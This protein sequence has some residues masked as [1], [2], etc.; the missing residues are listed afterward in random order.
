[1][2]TTIQVAKET[3]EKLDEMGAS[4]Y[5]ELVRQ[6]LVEHKTFK[7]S[8]FGKYRKLPRFSYD[9]KLIVLLDS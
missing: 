3:A 4:T 9:K 1:M 6:L 7:S 2:A 5:D 8:R